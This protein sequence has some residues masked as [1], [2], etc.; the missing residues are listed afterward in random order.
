MNT[1]FRGLIKRLWN[2]ISARRR[3]QYFLLLVLIF[4]GSLAEVI[5]IGAVLPFLGVLV[6]PEAI[7][8]HPAAQS[9]V[10]FFKLTEP[11]QLLLPLT[12]GFG[13]A[14]ISA[15]V[16][17]LLLLWVSTKLSFATGA[18][19][20]IEV[21]RR[22]LYQPYSFHCSRNSSELIVAIAGKT[23][24]I[25]Y[26]FLV[27]FIFVVNAAIVLLSVFLT[28]MLVN[29]SVALITFGTLTI[30]YG[31]IMLAKRKQLSR[32]SL[33]IASESVNLI[34]ALQEGLGG[35]R[36]VLIDG[37]QATY[38]RIYRKSDLAL[39]KAQAN[40]IFIGGAPR[41][42]ME[43]F[44]MVVIAILAYVL[45]QRPGGVTTAI[46]LLGA[47]ALGAQRCLPVL[48]GGYAALTTMQG[49]KANLEDALELLELPLPEYSDGRPPLKIPFEHNIE[50]NQV[51]FR[52]DSSYPLALKNLNFNIKKGSRVG[53][54]GPTGGG[55]SSLLDLIMGLIDPTNGIIKIDGVALTASNKRSWQSHI[56][57]VP[58]A[59]YLAD[60]SIAENIAFGIEQKDI[61]YERV[62][63]AAIQAQISNTIESWSK[64]YQT[65][66]G[67]RG[68]K[69][70]GGQRQRIGIARALY[71]KA[72]VIV[73]DEATSALDDETE[74]AVMQ[75]IEN[76]SSDLTLL[77]IAHRVTT[78]KNCNKIIKLV[79]GGIEKIGSY[80][81][82]IS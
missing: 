28:L 63:I 50:I 36:D 4:I 22:T 3:A 43:S 15:S 65:R 82:I 51:D 74:N 14:V 11:S 71:K 79:D 35:I 13:V 6:A 32:E 39:R 56:A 21:Y 67:E 42:F 68:I 38:S 75:S 49:G 80:N 30:I 45:V 23:D 31:L 47:L 77:I 78:L 40:N 41:F 12:I 73:F 70:S 17:R 52:Y 61:D 59:I 66:V 8:V 57:H 26:Q 34:K 7:F 33:I 44:G 18:D 54:I 19:L 29:T 81:E 5:S 76:L 25:I 72:N 24:S 62:K 1:T 9:T 64:K 55:K 2:C 16:M 60:S 58:Q 46:P 53:F 27:P 69:L 48:Q 37:T 10:Q 20:S